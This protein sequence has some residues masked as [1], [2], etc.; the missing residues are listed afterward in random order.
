MLAE[1]VAK[2][3]RFAPCQIRDPGGWYDVHRSFD[4]IWEG[5]EVSFEPVLRPLY[6]EYG[7]RLY[8]AAAREAIDRFPGFADHIVEDGPD[9]QE[10]RLVFTDRAHDL[11]LPFI[12]DRMYA[13][14]KDKAVSSTE[15]VV[16]GE[17]RPGIR[18]DNRRILPLHV[19]LD[20]PVTD[21]ATWQEVQ[22]CF[23][24]GRM[25]PLDP[26]PR[27]CDFGLVRSMLC[28]LSWL[29]LAYLNWGEVRKPLT[30]ADEALFAAV[31]LFDPAAIA[32]SLA[33][34][35]DP[36]ALDN[37]DETPLTQL[38]ST[39][40]WHSITPKDGESWED[41]RSRAQSVAFEDR[42]ACMEVLLD[43]GAH[44]DLCGPDGTTALTVAVLNKDDKLLEWLLMLGADDTADGFDDSSPGDWPPAWDFAASDLTVEPGPASERVWQL[45]RRYRQAPNGTR[46]GERPDW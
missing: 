42:K 9:I 16:I 33:A 10:R 7:T 36:N 44:V 21:E 26:S 6:M 14:D 12:V 29:E 13:L 1:D 45:L 43:A 38:A 46:P 15:S 34:G 37:G 8:E 41:A 30:R 27:Q 19:T 39:E 5:E 24:A 18:V 40:P 28:D 32:R 31:H 11:V 4:G 2:A 3:M 20:R 23:S 25:L 22:G 35:A 17:A